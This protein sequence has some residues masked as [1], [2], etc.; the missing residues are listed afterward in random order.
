MSGWSGVALAGFGAG[1]G[2]ALEPENLGKLVALTNKLKWDQKQK[3]VTDQVEKE[4]KAMEEEQVK[5]NPVDSISGE[6]VVTE[7]KDFRID[8][9]ASNNFDISEIS[10]VNPNLSL[11][12]TSPTNT[13][14]T[15]TQYV[16]SADVKSQPEPV[17]RYKYMP[18]E[19]M[20]K[21]ILNQRLMESAMGSNNMAAAQEAASQ[22]EYFN[23]INA[24]EIQNSTIQGMLRN[25]P[26]KIQDGVNMF[27]LGRNQAV[28]KE[29]S[30]LPK[31]EQY[32]MNP[33]TGLPEK[34]LVYP[35]G[36]RVSMDDLNTMF[37]SN[38]SELTKP[39]QYSRGG[40]GSGGRPT[41]SNLFYTI[42]ARGEIENASK[43]VHEISSTMTFH[44]D[45]N[46]PVSGDGVYSNVL[47][48]LSQYTNNPTLFNSLQNILM[49][50]DEA[51]KNKGIAGL[52]LAPFEVPT[53]KDGTPLFDDEKIAAEVRPY[54]YQLR[55]EQDDGSIKTKYYI[56]FPQMA[57]KFIQYSG[58][59]KKIED[60]SP[61][62]ITNIKSS[63]TAPFPTGND[64]EKLKI[65]RAAWHKGLVEH[66]LSKTDFQVQD[67][68]TAHIIANNVL[69][70]YLRD[71]KTIPITTPSLSSSNEPSF[72]SSLYW[73]GKPVS[74]EFVQK[75]QGIGARISDGLGSLKNDMWKDDP[76]RKPI[77]A[78]PR[79][80][81]AS[82]DYD[83]PRA[84]EEGYVP[85]EKGKMPS[86]AK[87]NKREIN[88][89]E[90]PPGT[91]VSI[92][93][94]DHP[95]LDKSIDAEVTAEGGPRRPVQ[96]TTNGKIFFI[97][98][99]AAL[100]PNMIEFKIKTPSSP[101]NSENQSS[102]TQPS[103]D[104]KVP[105]NERNN[106]P[107][108]LEY[109]GQR[110]ATSDGRFAIFQTPQDGFN[111]L[112]RQIKLDGSRGHS[113]SSFIQ[114]YA[115][116]SENKTEQYI[117]FVSGKTGIGSYEKIAGK[118]IESIALA[119][120]EMEG[121]KRSLNYFKNNISLTSQ[122]A[123]GKPNQVTPMAMMNIS[124]PRA[125]T[126]ES[127]FDTALDD[128]EGIYKTVQNS[129][130][131]TGKK[132]K[133]SK[134]NS[135]VPFVAT[136]AG[137]IDNL[138][139]GLT[140]EK[141]E[142]RFSNKSST[143]K[144]KTAIGKPIDSESS[145]GLTSIL[146]PLPPPVKFLIVGGLKALEYGN[147]DKNYSNIIGRTDVQAFVEVLKDREV[148]PGAVAGADWNATTES[149]WDL[150][151]R[152]FAYGGFSYNITERNK[153]GYP[154]KFTFKDTYDFNNSQRRLRVEQVEKEKASV[155]FYQAFKNNWERSLKYVRSPEFTG[156]GQPIYEGSSVEANWGTEL[157]SRTVGEFFLATGKGAS[158]DSEIT[159]EYDKNNK[160]TDYKIIQIP[161][162]R[163][164]TPVL[165]AR[166]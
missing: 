129:L 134:N 88:L 89:Y 24:T 93:G 97:P 12:S 18:S 105:L 62:T 57:T 84:A 107:G 145:S 31:F 150:A 118:D 147:E 162:V 26:A 152:Q 92:K 80:F 27:Y 100:P 38:L 28:P 11:G 117:D 6:K 17:T 98:Q 120:T 36:S 146:R 65:E 91:Y 56:N 137:I 60:D 160:V 71:P 58:E 10:K 112:V 41:G 127:M 67:G 159:V 55:T 68:G 61:S 143:L 133:V 48:T 157:F 77:G 50:P 135:T 85:D 106:N 82:G 148:G 79:Y 125:K 15:N 140:L 113:L 5:D 63:Y 1:I 13:Q 101:M 69:D 49:D 25:D 40:A 128:I 109:K 83:Y 19:N 70:G 72:L 14:P 116:K 34:F 53:G 102:R 87:A 59:A 74:N 115:P 139:K 64:K 46:K 3:E 75:V 32:G 151:N 119:M 103:S 154:I 29:F 73:N 114:K 94:P 144:S 22:F 52:F 104:D 141:L 51:L 78:D 39:S 108:A 33:E 4:F 2:K 9:K 44:N 138:G 20:K 81:R 161:I 142:K 23:K 86:V 149:K 8:P 76:N 165:T 66:I 95:T 43:Q 136:I 166:K 37:S 96:S 153:D 124:G 164:S 163:K 110:G 35:S 122:N 30:G 131:P 156:V 45:N 47:R 54:L 21:Q 155:G 16:K 90:L 158:F 111:A 130:S 123:Q 121:G 132:S 99:S 7:S 42:N 126:V